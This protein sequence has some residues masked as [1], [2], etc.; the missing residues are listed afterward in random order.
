MVAFV[1][2][3]LCN[4]LPEWTAHQW[5]DLG[6]ARRAERTRSSQLSLSPRFDAALH[7]VI[8]EKLHLSGQAVH[9]LQFAGYAIEEMPGDPLLLDWE[10]GV[11]RWH[12]QRTR[13]HAGLD[14][15]REAP[16]SS[17]GDVAQPA[18]SQTSTDE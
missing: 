7:A 6:Q 14:W 18:D 16:E 4:E 12:C 17:G 13:H 9:A 11:P 10:A 15:R 1:T 5:R 2:G 8:S 3:L